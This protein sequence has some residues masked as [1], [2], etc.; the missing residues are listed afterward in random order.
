MKVVTWK[1]LHGI[2]SRGNDH[3]NRRPKRILEV[4]Q[5]GGIAARG[6]GEG[7]GETSC[8]HNGQSG[9]VRESSDSSHWEKKSKMTDRRIRM[10]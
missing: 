5:R 8:L 3:R 10:V 6:R 4:Q 2:D 9:R 7:T 1:V